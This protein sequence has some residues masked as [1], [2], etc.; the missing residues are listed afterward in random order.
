MKNKIT[1]VAKNLDIIANVGGKI[2][3]G[4]GVI[5]V[6]VAFFTLIFGTIMFTAA[7]ITLNLDF[8]KFHLN[9]N[10]IVNSDYMKIY[11][12]SATLGGGI[13][14]FIVYYIS[15]VIRKIIAPMKLGRPFESGIS[16]NL[17]K[18]GLIVLI[19]GFFSEMVGVIARLLMINAYSI[20]ELFISEVIEKTEFLFNINLNFVLISCV[21][22]FLSYIFTYGQILQQES[23][24]TL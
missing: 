5:C 23:D 9:S 18:I 8:I 7:D 3:A 19:G 16:E 15:R 20:N 11:I 17:K 24:E 10:Y 6:L 12:F 1:Q 21:I 22:F 4:A 13:I 14:C 2:T